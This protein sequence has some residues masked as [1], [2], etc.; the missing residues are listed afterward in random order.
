V[1]FSGSV[2]AAAVVTLLEVVPT[3]TVTATL[4]EPSVIQAGTTEVQAIGTGADGKTTY[5]QHNIVSYYALVYPLPDDPVATA[6][7]TLISEAQT[8]A[9]QFI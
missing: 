9:G 3:K 2:Y 1:T 4:N 8:L 7:T 6:T 5:V